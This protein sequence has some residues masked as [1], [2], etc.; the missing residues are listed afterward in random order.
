MIMAELCNKQRQ[1]RVGRDYA[2]RGAD[3]V[4]PNT[5]LL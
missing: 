1:S 2:N 3:W 4:N 5:L